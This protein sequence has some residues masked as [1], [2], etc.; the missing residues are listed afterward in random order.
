LENFSNYRKLEN[1]EK[2]ILKIR[3]NEPELFIKKA[4]EF[5]HLYETYS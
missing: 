5:C 2:E 4:D 3:E 1:L